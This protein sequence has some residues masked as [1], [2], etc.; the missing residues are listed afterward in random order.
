MQRLRTALVNRNYARLW[1]GEA[2]S[3]VG[4]YMFDTTLVLWVATGLA[5]GKP[6]A[7]AAVSGVLVA[8]GA[9]VL[10]VGPFA[11]VF[12][13]RWSPVATML[14]TE[15]I[16]AALAAALAALTFLPTRDL[17]R[18]AWLFVLYA[19]VFLLNAAGQFFAPARL[20]TIGDL[21]AG[22][23]DRA[24]AA[25]LGQATM[26]AAAIIGPPLAAPLVFTF[27][28]QWA[29]AANAASYLV[30]YTTIRS[31]RLPRREV[32]GAW[33]GA[34]LRGDFVAG[35][36][37]FAGNRFLVGLLSITVICQLGT[38]TI[39]ALNVF[40][41]TRNLHGGPGMYVVMSTVFGAGAILGALGAGAVVRRLGSRATIW[42]GLIVCGAVFLVYARQSSLWAGL[43][44]LAVFGVPLA[45]LNTAAIPFLL[46]V[47]PGEYLGRMFAVFN[48]VNQLA[49]VLSVALAGFV[50]ST[51]LDGFRVT[52]GGVRFGAID[53]VFVV[54]AL[55]IL[56]A[57]LVAY[58][59][60]PQ[61][62][63]LP[64][65]SSVPPVVAPP[66]VSTGDGPEAGTKAA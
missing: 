40:F 2:V 20:A 21:V 55:L 51:A 18:W 54:G 7:P 23:A 12:V 58:R 14:R 6:W 38:G 53:T 59:V 50:A 5:R 48:P 26:A 57:G 39:P 1:Y 17:P 46:A 35:L 32:P 16:R 9:A 61:P 13:D 19:V 42:A 34:G 60:L 41:V 37:F 64:S 43:V 63:R 24:R 56:G 29:L 47:T 27:G 62:E 31:L 52:A 10:V 11:G 44:L 45:V 36:R 49:S 25:G 22:E 66:A 8:A 3:A 15:V 30:S 28:L 65:P 33:G 4:D